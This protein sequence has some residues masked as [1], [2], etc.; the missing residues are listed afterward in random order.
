MQEKPKKMMNSRVSIRLPGDFDMVIP[1]SFEPEKFHRTDE[2]LITE[3]DVKKSRQAGT[4]SPEKEG[5][6]LTRE[7]LHRQQDRDLRRKMK[8]LQNEFLKLQTQ[9]KDFDSYRQLLGTVQ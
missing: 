2:T 9:K 1:D 3:P 6:E 8:K 4:I 7:E 5:R